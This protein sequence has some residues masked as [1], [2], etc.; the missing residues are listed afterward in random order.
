MKKALIGK[1][2][3]GVKYKYPNRSCK[4]CRRFPC[5]E[6]IEICKSDFAKYGCSQYLE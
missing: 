4:Q 5:F 3:E 6:G 2:E 1:D